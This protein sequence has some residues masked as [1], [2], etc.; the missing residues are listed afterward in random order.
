MEVASHEARALLSSLLEGFVVNFRTKASVA[1]AA[2]S[3]LE[4]PLQICIG[5]LP[6]EVGIYRTPSEE[7]LVEGYVS[8]ADLELVLG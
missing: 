4:S 6:L 7:C 5:E 1:V 3:A 2:D 8:L